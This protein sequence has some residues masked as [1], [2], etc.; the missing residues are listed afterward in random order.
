[1]YKY[2]IL[3]TWQNS[4]GRFTLS[5]LS[6]IYVILASACLCLFRVR[7]G[8]QAELVINSSNTAKIDDLIII[9]KQHL[10]INIYSIIDNI[11]W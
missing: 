8:A 10:Y 5:A 2:L 3:Q 6:R 7:V 1:M 4:T 9:N 11:K